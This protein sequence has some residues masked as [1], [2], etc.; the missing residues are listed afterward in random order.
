MKLFLYL[1]ISP[2]LYI[3]CSICISSF[4]HYM[5][6]L[7]FSYLLYSNF[8]SYLTHRFAQAFLSSLYSKMAQIIPTHNTHVTFYIRMTTSHLSDVEFIAAGFTAIS[9]NIHDALR[10]V[11]H[12][13][14]LQSWQG[15][16]IHLL[17]FTALA[18]DSPNDVSGWFVD[19]Q[20]QL[21][22]HQR[23]ATFSSRIITVQIAY[24][25]YQIAHD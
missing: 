20:E 15:L 18:R 11:L 23:F 17:V 1:A 2:S 19:R 6:L 9:N 13:Q 12:E 25:Y 16:M 24:H 4:G 14:A 7:W 5:I 10:Q 3:I 8:L 22:W 21:N